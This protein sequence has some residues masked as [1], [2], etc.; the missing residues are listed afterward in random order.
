MT[1]IW[2]ESKRAEGSAMQAYRSLLVRAGKSVPDLSCAAGG[3][4]SEPVSP[5]YPP[6][7]VKLRSCKITEYR[8]LARL[9]GSGRACPHSDVD[10]AVGC[11]LRRGCTTS[12][13]GSHGRRPPSTLCSGV[14]LS[15]MGTSGVGF[16][17][18]VMDATSVDLVSSA[19]VGRVV[20]SVAALPT[21]RH[22][23]ISGQPRRWARWLDGP[24]RQISSAHA[25]VRRPPRLL[26]RGEA[27]E[28]PRTR[29]VPR[30]RSRRAPIGSR[31]GRWQARRRHRRHRC[32][33]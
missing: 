23:P 30:I 16:V 5:P 17:K 8:C 12:T 13:F 27:A 3:P 14:S 6:D 24:T 31:S 9:Y 22:P 15:S 32:R 10:G 21:V 11:G 33:L 20:P 1:S 18:S 26:L 29:A 25:S 28:P 4:Q 2:I 7:V 19:R